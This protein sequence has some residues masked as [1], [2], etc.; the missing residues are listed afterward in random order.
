MCLRQNK[1]KIVT[2]N[3]NKH[4]TTKQHLSSF[5]TL[6]K[7]IPFLI[8]SQPSLMI[9]KALHTFFSLPQ[10]Y[11][12]SFFSHQQDG[13]DTLLSAQSRAKICSNLA[14]QRY[15]NSKP[16]ERRPVHAAAPGFWTQT[17][18]SSPP[19]RKVSI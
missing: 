18:L 4:K 14:G 15:I 9:S 7:N 5:N 1:P 6:E 17:T 13:R 16:E 2:Q 11:S 19:L 10:F 8:K 3:D 12:F